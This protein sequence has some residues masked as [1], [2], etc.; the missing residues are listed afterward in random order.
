LRQTAKTIARKAGVD[1]NVRMVIFGH[2]NG[3]DMDLRYDTVDE[4]DLM[5]AI[6]KIE[7]DLEDSHSHSH[8]CIK[9]ALKTESLNCV[10]F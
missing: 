6:D 5:D 4:G 10:N 7:T 9:K 1:K 8:Y 3:N 2:S